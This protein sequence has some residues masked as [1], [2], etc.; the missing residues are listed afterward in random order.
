MAQKAI[1]GVW[2][3][4][5]TSLTVP[6]FVVNLDF[7]NSPAGES[8]ASSAGKLASETFLFAR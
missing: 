1:L 6:L 8:S 2:T 5:Q 3:H 7:F 4:G